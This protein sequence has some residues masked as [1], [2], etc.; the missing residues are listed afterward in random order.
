MY[1]PVTTG[2]F[3]FNIC[4]TTEKFQSHKL[5]GSVQ[6]P[7]FSGFQTLTV[8]TVSVSKLEAHMSEIQ[9]LDSLDCFI[10]YLKVAFDTNRLVQ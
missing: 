2:I 10:A 8:C 6:N 9:T 1:M 5:F 3:Y 7:D 4:M